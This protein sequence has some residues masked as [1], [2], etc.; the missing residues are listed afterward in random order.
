VPQYRIPR[1][2]DVDLVFDGE[3]LVD[4]SNRR[5]GADYWTEIRIFR[6]GTGKYVAEMV[7]K[8]ALGDPDRRNITVVDDPAELREALKRR[9]R[10]K[11]E[12]SAKPVYLT[13]FARDALIEAARR[14]PAV[15]AALEER[16]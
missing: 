4:V 11:G 12:E 14:D 16:I 15:S 5:D 7:G 6:T 9:R 2:R 10:A 13:H 3:C 8:S 1:P